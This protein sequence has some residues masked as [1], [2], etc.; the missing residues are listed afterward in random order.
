MIIPN[1]KINNL[2]EFLSTSSLLKET[3]GHPD[4]SIAVLDGPVDETHSC[5]AGARLK[6]IDF[7]NSKI[8]VN[9]PAT[10]H[11]THITS[12]IFGQHTSNVRGIAPECQGLLF[13]LFK[14]GNAGNLIP[15]SQ[16]ELAQAI[17]RAVEQGAN[18]I[19][20]SGGELDSSGEGSDF[21]S[22]AICNAHENGV[23]IIAAAGNNGCDCLHVP[24]AMPS[25]LAVGAMDESGNPMEFSNWGQQYQTQGILA[26]GQNIPGAGPNDSI[27]LKTGTSFATPIVSGV[28]ALLLS[29]Q[30]K[31]GLKMDPQAVRDAI[32]KSGDSCEKTE[33]QHCLMGRLNIEEARKHLFSKHTGAIASQTKSSLDGKEQEF[34]T[35]IF[36]SEFLSKLDSE[37]IPSSESEPRASKDPLINT[38]V[39]INKNKGEKIMENNKTEVASFEDVAV[40]DQNLDQTT[41]S[42]I[43]LSEHTLEEPKTQSLEMTSKPETVSIVSPSNI[44]P[45]ACACSGGGA[46]TPSLVYVLGQLNYDFGNEANKDSFAQRMDSNTS[47]DN[48]IQF[49]DYLNKSPLNMAGAQSVIWTLTI[50][51]NPIYAIYPV[52][53][54]ASLTYSQIVDFFKDQVEKGVERVS[55]PGTISGTVKLMSGQEVPVVV[56]DLRAMFNWKTKNIW[57]QLIKETKGNDNEVKAKLNNFLARVYYEMR[58]FGLSASDRAINFAGTN[59]FMA[60]EIFENAHKEDLDLLTISAEKSSICRPGSNCWDIKLKFFNPKKVLEAAKVVYTITIDVSDVI[61][62]SVGSF[63]KFSEY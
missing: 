49:L 63:R 51:D 12:I 13:P 53:A 60:A 27:V 35:E 58:N 20:I 44:L 2:E 55:I 36:S 26:P 61:P 38:E 37:V 41:E 25:V 62:V 46:T 15:S 31:Q 11:G 34:K 40:E 7:N 43:Q 14:D 4:I 32:L 57:E 18:I 16:L 50:E 33:D 19:N 56:P 30:L 22:D 54:Y 23:L 48:S 10:R 9:G 59:A 3:Q 24:A 1:T 8:K 47:P 52:G 45:S 21:L 17:T 28:A 29:L 39:N 6:Y 42:S 5:F